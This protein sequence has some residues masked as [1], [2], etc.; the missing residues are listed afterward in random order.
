MVLLMRVWVRMRANSLPM[1]HVVLLVLLLVVR[2]GVVVVL[3]LSM[4][5][6]RR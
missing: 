4:Y 1:M 3:R 5:L 2:V 6:V